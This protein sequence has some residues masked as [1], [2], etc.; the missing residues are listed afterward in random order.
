MWS[1]PPPL[2]FIETLGLGDIDLRF[3]SLD[4]K[5]VATNR[6]SEYSYI[7]MYFQSLNCFIIGVPM[8][9]LLLCFKLMVHKN[10][11]FH[12]FIN[13]YS[14]YYTCVLSLC[15]HGFIIGTQ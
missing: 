9:A 5:V 11:V 10:L 3:A 2:H 4:I 6:T 14:T 8:A 7:Y 13:Y 15:V 12:R 1:P